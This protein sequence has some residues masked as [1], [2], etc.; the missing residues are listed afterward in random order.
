MPRTVLTRLGIKPRK[1]QGELSC[2]FDLVKH[3]SQRIIYYLE[4]D[5]KDYLD[6]LHFRL[7]KRNFFDFRGKG[8][9][10]K[11]DGTGFYHD[12][13]CKSKDRDK[14]VKRITARIENFRKIMASDTPVLF[15][16][17]LI[18]NDIDLKRLYN[19]LNKVRG[20]KFFKVIIFDFINATSDNDDFYII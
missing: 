1:A 13:D 3:N 17:N 5:F 20:N 11:N 15:V 14:L 2:P 10:Q 12:K 9:W 7:R 16:M 18:D 4:T 6:D 8:V 19:V